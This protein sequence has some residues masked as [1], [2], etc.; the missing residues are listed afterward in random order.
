MISVKMI[1]IVYLIRREMDRGQVMSLLPYFVTLSYLL[2]DLKY[3][4]KY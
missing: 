2:I 4:L 3:F 1:E